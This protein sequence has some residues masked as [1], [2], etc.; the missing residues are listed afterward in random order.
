MHEIKDEQ[1][2]ETGSKRAD[3]FSTDF[4]SDSQKGSEAFQPKLQDISID[5]S[6]SSPSFTK[7][8]KRAAWI[9]AALVIFIYIWDTA[10]HSQV[11]VDVSSDASEA[12]EMHMSK[13]LAAGTRLLEKDESYIGGDLTI[14]HSSEEEETTIYVW[15]YA[16][17]DGD[18]VQILVNGN[19]LGDPFMIKNKPVSFSIPA[20]GEVQVLGTRDGGGGITYGVYYEVNH[21]TYFNGMD[22]GGDNLYTLIRE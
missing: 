13:S 1:M 3:V 16:A 6:D 8:I 4:I 11:K 20:V 14:S 5:D 22:E 18:Y 2:K 21:T 9:F 7:R 17:E 19:S 15:D 12:M 10:F